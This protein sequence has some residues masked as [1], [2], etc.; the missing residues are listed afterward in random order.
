MLG[1]GRR[2]DMEGLGGSAVGVMGS[3]MGE[4]PPHRGWGWEE[5][6]GQDMR[7]EAA[8]GNGVI[9]RSGGGQNLGEQVEE[10]ATILMEQK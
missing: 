3:G 2:A 6:W 8:R 4:G 9:A 1:R 7:G 10:E 5:T